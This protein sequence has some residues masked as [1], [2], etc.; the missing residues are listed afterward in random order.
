MKVTMSKARIFWMSTILI[1]VINFYCPA[2]ASEAASLKGSHISF[3]SAELAFPEILAQEDIKLYR[4]IFNIQETG[5][6]KRAD[7]LIA[8]LK[9][10]SLMGHILSQRYLHPTKYRSR[11]K[12]LKAW[13]AKYADNPDAPRLYKLARLRQPKNYRAPKRPINV[14]YQIITPRNTTSISIP[15]RKLSRKKRQRV[16]ALK[17]IIRSRLR[18]G[19]TLSAK[20]HIKSKEIKHLFSIPEYDQAKA[21]LGQGYFLAGRDSWALMWAGDAADRS[22]HL[23]PEAHWTAGLA[24]WRLKK[25]DIAAEHFESIANN[26]KVSSWLRSAGAFWAARAHLINRKPEL[27]NPYLIKAS[28]NMRTFYGLIANHILGQPTNFRWAIPPLGETTLARLK[29]MPRGRRAIALLQVGENRRAERELRNLGAFADKAITEA[30]LVLASRSPM[31]SLAVRIDRRLFPNGGGYDGAAYPLPGWLPKDGLRVDRALI[32]AMIRQESRFNPKAKSWAGARGLMQL[33]PR[34]A[35]FVAQD[36][37]FHRQDGKRRTLFK[38]EVNLELG[39]KYIEILLAD[40]NIKGN[41][42][43]MATAWNG[44]PGNLIKWRRKTEYMNDPLFFIESIPS[45]ETRIFIEKVLSNLWIY[46]DQLGQ[47]APS[48]AAIAAG[49][50]PLYVPLGQEPSEVAEIDRTR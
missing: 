41:L 21:R 35:S 34:T 39:Q 26:E 12:E 36:R 8:G 44:G 48:L 47:P 4:S 1:I 23:L 32:Y 18:R 33:M 13:M 42:F 49:K 25:I 19:F 27:V 5:D 11:Y 38:P 7:E 2:F 29:E 37:R 28:K 6:W 17:R 45:L 10:K 24:A 14:P 40:E 3:N 20:Q 9:D 30:I 31:P 46:R 16:R 43:F 15:G 50:W 22:G